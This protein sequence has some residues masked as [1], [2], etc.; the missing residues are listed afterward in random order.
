METPKENPNNIEDLTNLE[1]RVSSATKLTLLDLNS[2][3][4]D[5]KHT[6]L[7][8]DYLERLSRGEISAN[9]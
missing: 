2:I 3:K 6:I 9:N 7:T 8:P 5:V 1:K 4:L